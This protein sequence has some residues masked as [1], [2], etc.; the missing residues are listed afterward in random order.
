MATI[1]KQN[2]INIGE[3]GLYQWLRDNG[4]VI[5]ANRS[6]KNMPTAKAMKLGVLEIKEGTRA[7]SYGKKLT[8]TTVV[9]PKG[10]EYFLN[11][12]LAKEVGEE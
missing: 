2:G 4:Y 8:K 6:D 3:T 1:L 7:S 10:Q 12:F 9:T 5:K 11:K